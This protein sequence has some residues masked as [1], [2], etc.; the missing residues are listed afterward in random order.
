MGAE[1]PR[2][3]KRIIFYTV[4]QARLQFQLLRNL[5]FRMMLAMC[6]WR[7]V[8]VVNIYCNRQIK[9]F[10]CQFFSTSCSSRS[11]PT[12]ASA[13]FLLYFSS[14]CLLAKRLRQNHYAATIGVDNIPNLRR[15]RPDTEKLDGTVVICGGR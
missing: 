6:Y 12:V 11:P 4:R 15:V 5:A 13:I 14:C 1:R 7:T 3:H 9:R 8:V 10:M 2:Q